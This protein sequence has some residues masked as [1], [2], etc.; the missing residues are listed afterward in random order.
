MHVESLSRMR[1]AHAGDKSFNRI[2]SG[3]G[4][5]FEK[6][7]TSGLNTKKWGN[8]VT[9][10]YRLKCL[11][12]FVTLSSM[13]EGQ[14]KPKKFDH[15]L[16]KGPL[17]E[18]LSDIVVTPASPTVVLFGKE[19]KRVPLE[20]IMDSFNARVGQTR[21]FFSMLPELVEYFVEQTKNPEWRNMPTEPT[22]M[23]RVE[24]E[25]WEVSVGEYKERFTREQLE[26]RVIETLLPPEEETTHQPNW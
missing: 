9:N 13:T 3:I 26:Q 16:L 23:E 1:L 14:P 18:W 22:S 11:L 12:V 5:K 20:L 21:G 7:S 25:L 4:M 6:I 10:C 2:M 19:K 8:I 15:P 17:P 24:E